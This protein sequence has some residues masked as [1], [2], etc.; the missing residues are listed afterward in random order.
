MVSEGSQVNQFKEHPQVHLIIW[1]T[2]E[3]ISYFDLKNEP[4]EHVVPQ[5]DLL[6]FEIFMLGLSLPMNPQTLEIKFTTSTKYYNVVSWL[7]FYN[8][9]HPH[10][11]NQT[12][13]SLVQAKGYKMNLL[14]NVWW[15][16]FPLLR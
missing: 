2:F 14:T 15:N 8:Y 3:I 10:S 11:H 5:L 12:K 6:D 13:V 7:L 9:E 16:T 4:H 1:G